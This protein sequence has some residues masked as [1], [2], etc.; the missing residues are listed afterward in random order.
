[1]ETEGDSGDD[2]EVRDSRKSMTIE[3]CVG[4]NVPYHSK[5][6]VML[7]LRRGPLWYFRTSGCF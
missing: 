2:V 1:M 6:S 5:W 3:R 7:P 4:V